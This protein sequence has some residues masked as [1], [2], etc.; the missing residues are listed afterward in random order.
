MFII[1][2]DLF[3]VD[4]HNQITLDFL[5]DPLKEIF[6]SHRKNFYLSNCWQVIRHRDPEL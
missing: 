3:P 4:D 1:Q 6:S 5:G 2:E